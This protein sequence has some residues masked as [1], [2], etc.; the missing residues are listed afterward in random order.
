MATGT[1]P[2]LDIITGKTIRFICYKWGTLAAPI[3]FLYD[4]VKQNFF[5]TL[6]A[7][8]VNAHVEAITF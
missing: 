3:A 6:L 1:F 7:C 5:I 2:N 8:A 4:L